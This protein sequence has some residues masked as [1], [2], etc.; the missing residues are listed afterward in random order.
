LTTKSVVWSISKAQATCLHYVAVGDPS[1]TTMKIVSG[2][3]STISVYSS[4]NTGAADDDQVHCITAASSVV[5]V[6]WHP[7]QTHVVAGTQDAIL[8][9]RTA[10][11]GALE[12]IST[13]V[14]HSGTT[15]ESQAAMTCGVL[16]PDGLIYI[17]GTASGDLQIWDLKNKAHAGVLKGDDDDAVVSVTFSNNGYH[18]AAVY[19]SG[20]VKVWDLRKQTVVASLNVDVSDDHHLAIVSA[21]SFDPSGKFLAYGGPKGIRVSTVK[22]W[23]VTA[24]FD[25]PADYLS[26]AGAATLVSASKKGRQIHI[27]Q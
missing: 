20:A 22:E 4:G 19:K 12:P 24:S 2:H 13:F 1:T 25:V 16:H 15:D 21:V 7:D 9:F 23:G 17:A 3:A 26:W 14:N 27:L 18:I 10:E 11:S 8:L 6:S 5:A